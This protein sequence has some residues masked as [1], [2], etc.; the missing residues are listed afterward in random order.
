MEINET[1]IEIS[2]RHDERKKMWHINKTF[3]MNSE[4]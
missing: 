4:L 2:H 3:S 1:A